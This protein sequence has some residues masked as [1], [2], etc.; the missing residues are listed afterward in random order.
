MIFNKRNGSCVSSNTQ[1]AF[2]W[3]A[4]LIGLLLRHKLERGEG[5]WISP[6]HSIHTLG[7]RFAI[8][9]I[10][11]DKKNCI[12]RMVEELQPN[13]VFISCSTSFSVLELPAGTIKNSMLKNG[14]YLVSLS[15]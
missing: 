6:C 7:M 13:R 15:E 5:L 8:D 9:V 12:K 3:V 2:S 4:R 11:L 14:D 1:Y 10:F